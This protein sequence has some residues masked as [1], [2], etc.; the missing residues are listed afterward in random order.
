[1]KPGLRVTL[2]K[3]PQVFA[4]IA[5]LR[6]RKVVI[7][8]P[9]SQDQRKQDEDGYVNP[10][11]NAALYYI[12]DMGSAAANVPQRETLRPG[13]EDVA[14][15]CATVLGQAAGAAF[16]DSS[17]IERGLMAAGLIAETGVK[18]RI[19]ASVNLEPLAPS[20]IAARKRK[21]IES[22]K[23]LIRTGSMLGAITHETRDK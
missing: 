21:G 6:K 11:G 18:K 7:G 15:Q 10:I 20:T 13:L 3:T 9:E 16:N 12:N 17:A 4:T 2:D 14:D 22:E 1:M 8:V 19:V 5:A 23:P